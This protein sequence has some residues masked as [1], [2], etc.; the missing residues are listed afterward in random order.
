MIPATWITVNA[1]PGAVPAV[2]S[3]PRRWARSAVPS[4][5]ADPAYGCPIVT[6]DPGGWLATA[7]PGALC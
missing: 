4:G 3:R 1:G 7:R 5:E 2:D 6:G